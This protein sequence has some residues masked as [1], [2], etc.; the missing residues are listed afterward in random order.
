MPN[1]P[2]LWYINFMGS[3]LPYDDT[4]DKDKLIDCDACGKRFLLY[5]DKF[6]LTDCL[7]NPSVRRQG[8]RILNNPFL[9]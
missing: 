7:Q 6:L 9:R 8:L 5:K 2:P 1:P 3:A 4:H